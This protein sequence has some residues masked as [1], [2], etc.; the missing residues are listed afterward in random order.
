M[1]RLVGALL[2]ATALPPV[3]WAQTES[4]VTLTR[5]DTTIV[6]TLKAQYADGARFIGNNPNCKP[7]MR[8]T[9]LY[10]PDPGYVDTRVGNDTELRSNVAI[11]LTPDT[12]GGTGAASGAPGTGPAAG[13]GTG[14]AGAAASGTAGTGTAGTAGAAGAGADAAAP[15]DAAAASPTQPAT[16]PATKPATTPAP[17]EEQTLEL[18]D[19]TVT[20]SRPGCIESEKRSQEPSVTLVQGRTTV[21]G[22]RF[23]LDQGSDTGTMDGPIQLDRAARGDSPALTA[24]ADRMLFDTQSRQATLLG[25]VKVT[26]QDRVTTADSLQLDEAAGVAVLAGKPARSTK[27]QDVLQGDRLRYYLNNNDVVVLG[28]V[29]GDLEV[30]IPSAP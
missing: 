19:G 4:Q 20:L 23:F 6:V 7:G 29:K 17:G 26:S 1:A 18:Y 27:G 28:A 11:V 22:T 9:L 5:K 25:N 13:S 24:S 21:K 30:T 10:G 12:S 16:K 8:Q 3:A 15:S 2:L 14:E